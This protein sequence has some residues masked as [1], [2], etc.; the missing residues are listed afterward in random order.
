MLEVTFQIF[1][2]CIIPLLGALTAWLIAFIN[3]KWEEVLI[4]TDS[5]LEKKYIN[6]LAQTITDCVLAT[7]QTYVD[8]LKKQGKFDL[9]AQ[10]IAFD[11]TYQAVLNILSADA[12]EYLQESVGDL[13]A[14]ITG[15]IEAEVKLNK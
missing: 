7:N 10:K 13:E 5:E 12:L 15:K 3:A 6:M 2:I 11:K 9:E 14:Y 8:E 1:Q 4:N